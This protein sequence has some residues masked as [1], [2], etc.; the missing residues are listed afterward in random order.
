MKPSKQTWLGLL[1]SVVACILLL[2]AALQAQ[3]AQA[4][5]MAYS[6]PPDED[7]VQQAVICNAE[8]QRCVFAAFS[9]EADLF[10]AYGGPL[11]VRPDDRMCMQADRHISNV[12]GAVDHTG[13]YVCWTVGSGY[14]AMDSGPI[15]LRD[16]T[17]AEQF[18]ELLQ[19][20][21]QEGT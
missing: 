9:L 20:A 8:E 15:L 16:N 11:I 5:V 6:T 7:G 2:S 1:F 13:Q 21:P 14:I 3:Q 12:P 17:M 4:T 18:R 19:S 10:N